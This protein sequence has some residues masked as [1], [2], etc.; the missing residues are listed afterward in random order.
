MRSCEKQNREVDQTY[1]L[2][3]QSRSSGP[4]LVFKCFVIDSIANTAVP[5]VVSKFGRS[6]G[7][8]SSAFERKIG[9]SMREYARRRRPKYRMMASKNGM[10]RPEPWVKYIVLVVER[11]RKIVV[12]DRDGVRPRLRYTSSVGQSIVGR[13]PPVCSGPSVVD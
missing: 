1:H 3:E 13:A 11:G 5:L 9:C 4:L 6:A 7:P 2:G 10:K 8:I 12:T